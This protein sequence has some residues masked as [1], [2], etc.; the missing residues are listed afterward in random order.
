[1]SRTRSFALVVTTLLLSMMAVEATAADTNVAR[2]SNVTPRRDTE[3]NI[4]DAHD[5]CLQKFGDRYYLYGTAYGKTDG[6]GKANRYRCYSSPDLMSWKLEGDLLKDP[7]G[8]RLLSPLRGLQRQDPEIRVLVQL[9]S[10]ALERPVRRSRQRHAA[11][12]VRD[13]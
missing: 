10:N 13:P 2:V 7:P 8:R 1:M 6:F 5:G 11:R 3:G 9:V 4:L 12:T